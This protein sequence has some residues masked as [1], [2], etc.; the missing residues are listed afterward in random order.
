MK[1]KT[2][3][4]SLILVGIIFQANGQSTKPSSIQMDLIKKSDNQYKTGWILLGTGAALS[5]TAIAIPNTY[6]YND[7][8]NNDTVRALLGW[9][10]FL[11]IGTS[12]PFF[13]S[14]GQNARTAARLSLESQALMQPIPFPGQ[15]NAFPS[16][17]LKIPL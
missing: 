9:T 7:G 15:P 8:S 3:W 16:L 11:S 1:M 14:A 5:I 10:G 6:D 13:L 4:L 2:I 12:I 17:S